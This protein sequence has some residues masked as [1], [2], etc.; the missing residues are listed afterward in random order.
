MLFDLIIYHIFFLKVFIYKNIFNT[1]FKK[2]CSIKYL[3]M[4][5]KLDIRK[6]KYNKENCCNKKKNIEMVDGM[7][8][9]LLNFFKGAILHKD[10]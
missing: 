5:K 9:R 6:K 10:N 7:K 4:S 3:H 8:A 1:A 2:I